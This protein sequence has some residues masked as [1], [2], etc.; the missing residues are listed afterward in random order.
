MSKKLDLNSEY[1]VVGPYTIQGGQFFGL[2]DDVGDKGD[3][4]AK[5]CRGRLEFIASQ[6]GLLYDESRSGVQSG[7]GHGRETMRLLNPGGSLIYEM[8]HINHC[9][10]PGYSCSY[11]H[12]PWYRY[13]EY[14]GDAPMDEDLA[15]ALSIKKQLEDKFAF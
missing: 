9:D 3:G 10:G 1:V 14:R 12:G 5:W 2:P 4:W 11:S 6:L 15:R 8:T 13:G 7:Y